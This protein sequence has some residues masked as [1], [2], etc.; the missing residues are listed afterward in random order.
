MSLVSL[1][2]F[3]EYLPEVQGTASDT[4]LQNLLD[5]VESVVA[6]FIGFHR[7]TAGPAGSSSAQLTSRSYTLYVDG[8]ADGYPNTIFLPMQPVTAITSWHSDVE[9]EYGSDKEIAADQYELDTNLGYLILKSTSSVTIESG[10]RA[11]K[12]VCSAGFTSAADD[13]THAVCVYA[14]ALQRGKATQ[15]KDSTTQRE[16]SVKLSPRTMPQEVKDI[17][18]PLR[19]SG[20]VL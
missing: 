19:V 8:P 10:F 15:G 7:I 1:A 2:T 6:A 17:L 9:R 13:I 4:E 12:I 3:K 14:S 5:R 18:Y 11:N 20:R 16:V